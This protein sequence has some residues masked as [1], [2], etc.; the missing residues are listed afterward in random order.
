MHIFWIIKELKRDILVLQLSNLLH[1]KHLNA[2]IHLGSLPTFYN[3]LGLPVALSSVSKQPNGISTSFL[4]YSNIWERKAKRSDLYMMLTNIS[5][6]TALGEK[7]S[8]TVFKIVSLQVQEVD[9]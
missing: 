1:K 8:P 5:W 2:L 3:H 4:M 9:S 6:L 7:A